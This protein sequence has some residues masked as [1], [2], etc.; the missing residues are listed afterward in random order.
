MKLKGK[1]AIVTGAS[2]RI[3]K[4]F[5]M[6]CPLRIPLLLYWPVQNKNV[7]LFLIP[8]TELQTIFTPQE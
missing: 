1:V 7:V 3:G 2:P 8:F 4:A 5:T 6:L